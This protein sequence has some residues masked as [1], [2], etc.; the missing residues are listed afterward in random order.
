[1]EKKIIE[2]GFIHVTGD[3]FQHKKRMYFITIKDT[4][5]MED[6]ANKIYEAGE[7]NK[8]SQIRRTLHLNEHS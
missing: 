7:L 6:V 1:M 4:D 3:I 8:I 2:L 5:K